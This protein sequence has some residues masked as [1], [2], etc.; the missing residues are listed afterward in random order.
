VPDAVQNL[1]EARHQARLE[2]RWTDADTLRQEIE[3]AGFSVRDMSDGPV[4]E[5]CAELRSA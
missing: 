5:P 4:S 2:K 3:A 1:I